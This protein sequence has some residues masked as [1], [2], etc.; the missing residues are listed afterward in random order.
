LNFINLSAG[1]SGNVSEVRGLN[2]GTELI[3]RVFAKKSAAPDYG[4]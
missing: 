2:L 1:P 3:P 4:K